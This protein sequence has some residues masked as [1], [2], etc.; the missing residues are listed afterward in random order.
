MKTEN[1]EKTGFVGRAKHYY[2]A[3]A[4]EVIRWVF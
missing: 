2:G 1:D 4:A 3:N